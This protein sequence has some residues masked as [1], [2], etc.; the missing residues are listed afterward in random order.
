MMEP[1]Y[2]KVTTL[3]G[4]APD[5]DLAGVVLDLDQK[6]TYNITPDRPMKMMF[7]DHAVKLD[8]NLLG[9]SMIPKNDTI[10]MFD[11]DRPV[12]IQFLDSNDDVKSSTLLYILL[13]L[14]G[15]LVLLACGQIG[16]MY[17]MAISWDSVCM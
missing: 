4:T 2:N 10:Y 12:R 11:S 3:D 16:Y 5:L 7:G 6:T 17:Y 13:G 1:E 9:T 8:G 14:V 15:T